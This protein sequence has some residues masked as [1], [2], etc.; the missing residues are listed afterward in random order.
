MSLALLARLI[1]VA[2]TTTTLPESGAQIIKN[3]KSWNDKD[4]NQRIQRTANIQHLQD[5]ARLIHV[6]SKLF[7]DHLLSKNQATKQLKAGCLLINNVSRVEGCRR[8]APGDVLTFVRLG[9]S[10]LHGRALEARA[11]FI[12]HML[13]CGL[14]VLR[15]DE[16]VA[17]V[18]KP[19]GIHT[20]HA[21]H[22]KYAAFEDALP[23]VLSPSRAQGGLTRPLAMHRLDVRVC[24]L[25]LVAKT[26]ASIMSLSHQFEHRRVAKRYEALLVGCPAGLGAV[27]QQIEVDSPVGNRPAASR[28]E[29]LALAPHPQWGLLAHVALWPKTG[30]THQLRIHCA[31]LACPIVGDD[32][33]WEHAITARD[34]YELAPIPRL[35]RGDGLYL[36]S[37]GVGYE[38]LWHVED[39]AF[40]DGKQGGS[41]IECKHREVIGCIEGNRGKSHVKGV[42]GDSYIL[43]EQWDTNI[44]GEQGVRYVE[45]NTPTPPRFKKLLTKAFEASAWQNG[46]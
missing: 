8:V 37:C 12:G 9:G 16:H 24:G 35:R 38:E 31:S 11:R 19:A 18:Y 10:Q 44:K 22:P 15:E 2:L 45:V 28:I 32:L 20:K 40:I 6:A 33:Y 21:T 39:E 27:G 1:P 29:L 5:D 43:G 25:V 30:R 42:Q 34:K 17:V 23:A 7:P 13:T 26:R 36:V 3:I 4:Q 14:R 46:A 41:R